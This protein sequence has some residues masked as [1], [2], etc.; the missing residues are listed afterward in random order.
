M[1]SGHGVRWWLVS[2][3]AAAS[4]RAV[5]PAAEAP[6]AGAAGLTDASAP[7]ATHDSGCR[8]TFR[9]GWAAPP[10]VTIDAGTGTRSRMGCGLLRLLGP[11]PP[12]THLP[13][14][15]SGPRNPAARELRAGDRAQPSGSD[16]SMM[17][18][19]S[20]KR[21]KAGQRQP[22]SNRRTNTTCRNGQLGEI[23]DCPATSTRAPNPW[24]K[25]SLPKFNAS[26]PHVRQSKQAT[27]KR[28]TSHH[29]SKIISRDTNVQAMPLRN[30][31]ALIHEHPRSLPKHCPMI[32]QPASTQDR[33]QRLQS[34]ASAF[35]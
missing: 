29:S 6:R 8:S 19:C 16:L 33:R 32:S 1:V 11:P 22:T 2:R 28:N 23:G 15:P 34:R 9:P 12:A 5:Y 26:E 18:I 14:C 21:S 17:P 7:A 3:T 4:C 35:A 27:P 24:R 20:P 25:S 31:P 10:S 30:A 13:A